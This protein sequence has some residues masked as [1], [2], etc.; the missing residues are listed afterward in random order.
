SRL[1]MVFKA[2]AN[3]ALD[4]VEDPRQMMD[5]AYEEQKQL[6]VKTKRGLVEVATSKALLQKQAE[7]LRGKVHKVEDQARRALGAGREDLARIALER[8]HTITAQIVEMDQQVTEVGEDERRLTETEQQ[9][10]MRIEEFKTRRDVVSARY[11]AA[12]AQVR[13]NEAFT[14]VSG[15]F[16]DLSMA[17]GRA[18]EKTERMQARAGAIGSLIESGALA[19][20]GE[21]SDR[22]EQELAKVTVER[23]IDDDMAALKAELEEG[24]GPP[25]L[26]SGN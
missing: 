8:K 15:E 17:L 9:L 26:K 5:Y 6:L 16:A 4:R 3:S 21:G 18:V 14:G 25:A 13:I 10:A 19:L 1:L 23:A 12:K 7:T 2:K 11:T 24:D 20:P 22:V